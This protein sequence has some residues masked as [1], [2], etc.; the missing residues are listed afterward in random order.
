[1]YELV[2]NNN[3]KHQLG[4]I[5]FPFNAVSDPKERDPN[6]SSLARIYLVKKQR[7]RVPYSAASPRLRPLAAQSRSSSQPDIILNPSSA[8]GFVRSKG[9]YGSDFAKGLVVLCDDECI[10]ILE[11]T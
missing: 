4:M 7:N 9:S 8:S 11:C 1:M 2:R 3:Y 10:G 6:N 5:L